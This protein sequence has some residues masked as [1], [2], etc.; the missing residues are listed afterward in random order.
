MPVKLEGSAQGTEDNITGCL[1]LPKGTEFFKGIPDYWDS[2]Y[3][4]NSIQEITH[5]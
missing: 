4:I 1:E 3:G 2:T 5:Q